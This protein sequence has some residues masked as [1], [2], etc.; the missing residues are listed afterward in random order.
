MKRSNLA[1]T[2]S[3]GLGL[4]GVP[5]MA[6]D[7][8]FGLLFGLGALVVGSIGLRKARDARWRRVAT[9]GLVVGAITLAGFVVAVILI[10]QEI[11]PLTGR[12]VGP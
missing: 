10:S 12:H 6:A 9:A 5:S 2:G 1:A 3:L 4:L 8:A 7:P 11:D